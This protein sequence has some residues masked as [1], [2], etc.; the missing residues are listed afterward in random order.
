M[1]FGNKTTVIVPFKKGTAV[2]DLR[3]HLDGP[4]ILG[5]LGKHL[6]DIDSIEKELE[7]SIKDHSREDVNE[8]TGEITV[9]EWR[10]TVLDRE[11][12]AVYHTRINARKLQIDTTLKMLNKVMPYLKAIETTDDIANSTERA[13]RAFA[14]AASEE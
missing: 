11:T 9:V 4:S 10:S 5:K 14:R 2:S 1:A 13:L 6:S 3:T 8:E 7:D 12:I